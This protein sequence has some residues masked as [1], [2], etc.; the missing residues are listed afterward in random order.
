V[1][2]AH[3]TAG[4]TPGRVEPLARLLSDRDL[5]Q[6]T[7][8]SRS[9]WQKDRVKG[10]GIPYVRVGRLIRYRADDVKRYLDQRTET[11]TSQRISAGRGA[12][13]PVSTT[14]AGRAA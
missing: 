3:P 4:A 2:P 12:E 10:G 7:G 6:I 13:S 5:E 1:K 11:S 9:S 14:A 8:R